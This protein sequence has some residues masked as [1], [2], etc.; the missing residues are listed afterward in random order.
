MYSAYSRFWISLILVVEEFWC[1]F[2]YL[3]LS[4]NTYQTLLERNQPTRLWR[5]IASV[6]GFRSFISPLFIVITRDS[7]FTF[8]VACSSSLT[9]LGMSLCVLWSTSLMLIHSSLA[10]GLLPLQLPLFFDVLVFHHRFSSQSLHCRVFVL[11]SRSLK[12]LFANS[13]FCSLLP[14]FSLYALLSFF[15]LFRLSFCLLY[16][17]HCAH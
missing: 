8:W 2:L 7:F 9:N 16:H 13:L 17:A 14:N 4:V 3:P 15:D 5:T 10:V 11:W 12:L 1:E 6:V